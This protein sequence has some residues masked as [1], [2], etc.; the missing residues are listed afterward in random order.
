VSGAS[1]FPPPTI[2]PRT[3]VLFS[4]DAAAPRGT[5][6]PVPRCLHSWSGLT[7]AEL[8][9]VETAFI[10]ILGLKPLYFRPPYGSINDLALQVLADR[11]YKK[12]FL[13]S[14][15]IGE[16][17]ESRALDLDSGY[18]RRSVFARKCGCTVLIGLG[19]ANGESVSYSDGV[20][21]NIINDYPNPHLVLDH[22][23]IQT[24]ESNTP[25][26]SSLHCGG[27]TAMAR[28][29]NFVA[30]RGRAEPSRC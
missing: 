12:V 13:W 26:L 19:D 15:D 18:T 3:P 6:C 7:L 4:S 25:I 20:Y 2:L 17:G 23:T 16:P 10:N 11:G 8:E 22:S 28:V 27:E 1:H 5:Y 14:D 9:K 21:W 30:S 29:S 24:S